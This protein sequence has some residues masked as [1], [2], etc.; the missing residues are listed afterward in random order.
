[1]CSCWTVLGTLA[2]LPRLS[3]LRRV[4]FG[5]SQIIDTR[6]LQDIFVWCPSQLE[7]G[8]E[9]MDTAER[10]WEGVFESG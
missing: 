7:T 5:S 4:H 10:S 6:G 8:G 3:T 9:G 2:Y 1:M